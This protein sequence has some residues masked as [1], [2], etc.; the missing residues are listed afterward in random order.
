MCKSSAELLSFNLILEEARRKPSSNNSTGRKKK[1][2]D[3][4]C[5][6]VLLD[7]DMGTNIVIR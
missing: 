6:H 5:H 2:S 7:K 3:T 1:N 4:M